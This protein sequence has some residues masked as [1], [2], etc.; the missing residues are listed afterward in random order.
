MSICYIVSAGK[1]EKA[2]LLKVEKKAGDLVICADAG[3][4]NAEKL[5]IKADVVVGDFDSSSMPDADSYGGNIT[6]H[7]AEKDETDTF[8]AMKTGYDMGYRKFV[9][10]GATGK[11]LDHTWAN[12][13]LLKWLCKNGAGGEIRDEYVR[14][15]MMMP[16]GGEIKRT[17]GYKLSLFPFDEAA[18]NIVLHGTKYHVEEKRLVNDFPLGVS[19]EFEE[20]TVKIELEKGALLVMLATDGEEWS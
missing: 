4:K 13:T 1:I 7:P 11:R 6:V 9:F 12:V 3:I 17:D 14:V 8:L 19:N 15:F 20:D 2:E 16:P 18:E 10:L 5:G